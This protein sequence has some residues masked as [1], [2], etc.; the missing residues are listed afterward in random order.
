M[1]EEDLKVIRESLV[2]VVIKYAC[3]R[4]VKRIRKT[5]EVWLGDKDKDNGIISSREVLV[6]HDSGRAELN[7]PILALGILKEVE[8][9]YG[10]NGSVFLWCDSSE[11]VG[12]GNGRHA[13]ELPPRA[14]GRNM[15]MVIQREF[16]WRGTDES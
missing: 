4:S 14:C 8:E 1:L 9:I 2:K 12:I 10:V 3:E 7:R 6:Q 11:V 5:V 15:D 16:W 13:K